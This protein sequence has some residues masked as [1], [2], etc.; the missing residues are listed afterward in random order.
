MPELQQP[1]SRKTEPTTKLKRDNEALADLSKLLKTTQDKA[2]NRDVASP[3]QAKIY[4]SELQLQ[5]LENRR[6]EQTSEL[7]KENEAL[8]AE[9]EQ[10]KEMLKK[11]AALN[12]KAEL[13][14]KDEILELECKEE[15]LQRQKESRK[16]TDMCLAQQ[17]EV[18]S[19]GPI[20]K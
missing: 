13:K 11:Q 8:A 1:G 12:N 18:S 15:S 14:R 5:Q 3:Q 20:P 7:K 10:L 17:T 2:C 6:T 16:E 19:H 9:I 4:L